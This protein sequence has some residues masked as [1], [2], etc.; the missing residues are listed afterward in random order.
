MSSHAVRESTGYLHQ[1]TKILPTHQADSIEH[2]S[3]AVG[4]LW[5]AESNDRTVSILL[6]GLPTLR[7]KLNPNRAGVSRESQ[8]LVFLELC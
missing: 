4:D 7:M 3:A 6:I 2:V 5:S 8:L 1:R